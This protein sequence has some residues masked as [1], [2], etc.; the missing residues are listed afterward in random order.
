MTQV[1]ATLNAEQPDATRAPLKVDAARAL[2]VADETTRTRLQSV[3]DRLSAALTVTGTVALDAASLGALEAITTTL[4]APVDLSA[5]TLSALEQVTATIANLPAAYPL[6]QTQLDALTP[7]AAP[8][9]Y[10][11]PAGQ[12]GALAQPDDYPLPLDQVAALAPPAIQPVSG[13]LTDAQLRA[14]RVLVDVEHDQPLTDAQ[15]RASRVPVDV[16]HEQ[17]LTD[18]QLRGAAVGVLAAQAG[19]WNVTVDVA[20]LLDIPTQ[21]SAEALGTSAVLLFTTPAECRTFVVTAHPDNTGPVRFGYAEGA[22][23][24]P[25]GPGAAEVREVGAGVPVWARS[26][27]GVQKVAWDVLTA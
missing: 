3:V 10:P 7:A 25:L 23:L 26:E 11:L 5:A 9:S 14:A 27:A 15:L 16:E 12:L 1:D 20:P 22:Q 21:G 8:D 17:P 24:F 6:P 4:T 18:A 2:L 13:P 19:D